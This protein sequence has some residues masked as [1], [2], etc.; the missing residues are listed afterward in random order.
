MTQSIV[1]SIITRQGAPGWVRNLAKHEP[2][3]EPVSS[4]PS[5]FYSSPCLSS[6]QLPSVTVS[7]LEV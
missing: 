1:G 7:G 6:S 2:G 3:S 4:I 5:G